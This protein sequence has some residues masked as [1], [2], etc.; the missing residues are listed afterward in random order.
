MNRSH[1]MIELDSS[2]SFPLEC[3]S[4][5]LIF[6]TLLKIM[7]INPWYMMAIPINS[8]QIKTYVVKAL[9]PVTSPLKII[10]QRFWFSKDFIKFVFDIGICNF[11]LCSCKESG[12]NQKQC[13]KNTRTICIFCIKEKV[14]WSYHNQHCRH[15][16]VI[17]QNTSSADIIPLEFNFNAKSCGII[18]MIF[19]KW[20][21]NVTIG[22]ITQLGELLSNFFNRCLILFVLKLNIIWMFKWKFKIMPKSLKFFRLYLMSV[23]YPKTNGRV[24]KR[25]AK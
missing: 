2:L 10:D 8:I 17:D 15:Q 7:R 3:I 13:H 22:V 1:L 23:L 25:N 16:M 12:Q 6:V 21:D 9:Y 20:F 14:D 19:L 5:S 24:W 11:Y 4:T 18:W